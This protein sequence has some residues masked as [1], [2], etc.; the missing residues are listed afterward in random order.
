MGLKLSEGPL[1]AILDDVEHPRQLQSLAA[2][3]DEVL[4][5]GEGLAG[6][7]EAQW[8]AA[9]STTLASC[10]RT[11]DGWRAQLHGF[12]P[13]VVRMDLRAIAGAYQ[14]LDIGIA[15]RATS[16]MAAALAHLGNSANRLASA[17]TDPA[18]AIWRTSSPHKAPPI[19]SFAI[20]SIPGLAEVAP[21]NPFSPG[22]LQPARHRFEELVGATS[23]LRDGGEWTQRVLALA[24]AGSLA[25]GRARL[26][27]LANAWAACGTHSS[28]T[29][30]TSRPWRSNHRPTSPRRAASIY[31]T[32]G[33]G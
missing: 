6:V 18:A 1:R 9:A 26:L 25:P 31:R 28:S 4:P 22:A 2:A 15:G 7:L 16:W 24:G 21:G 12:S 30:P 11:I 3:S 29:K 20:G 23:G 27:R 32:A 19:S 10:E 13:D 5:H 14:L 8:P 17:S 33:T